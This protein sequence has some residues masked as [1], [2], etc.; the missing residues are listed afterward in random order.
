MSSFIPQDDRLCAKKHFCKKIKE[1]LSTLASQNLGPKKKMNFIKAFLLLFLVSSCQVTE[2]ITINADGSGSIEVIQLRDENSYMQ[3]AGENYSRENVFRDTTY[4]FKEYIKN[5]NGNFIKYTNEE[6]KLFEKYTNVKVLIKESSF[7]K[8]FKSTFSLDFKKASEIPD[9]YKTEDYA[10]DI[11][12]NYALTAESHYYKIDY[13]FDGKIFKRLVSITNPAELQKTK[14][15]FKKAGFKYV[16][17]TQTYTLRYHF[18]KKIK[19]V[20]NEKAILS[21]DK[22]SLTLEFQLSE[23]LQNPEM[24]NLEVVLE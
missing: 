13:S 3:L 2:T 16:S 11:K 22:K 7:E 12:Y 6:Q 17:L 18:P 20:S 15:E 9:L 24:T 14:D 1:N 8:E 4:I 19:T 21:P 23:C 5:Y 10:D